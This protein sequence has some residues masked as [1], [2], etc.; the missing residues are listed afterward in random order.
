MRRAPS[1]VLVLYAFGITLGAL[2]VVNFVAAEALGVERAEFLRLGVEANLPSWFSTAQLLVVA[3]AFG[4]IAWRDVEVRRPGTWAAALPGLFFLLLS[5]DEGAQV[6]ERLGRVLEAQT[7]V[8]SGLMTGGWMFVAV[9]LY[10]A[11]ALYAARALA[12]Y[13]RGRPLVVRL[14]VAGCVLFVL[15]AAGLESLGNLTAAEDAFS[16]S[17]LGVFEE[18]GEML[19]ATT[20]LWAGVELA[21]AEGFR[22][23]APAARRRPARRT[24]AER[25][26][27][28]R[29]EP[30]APPP[31]F[32][33]VSP[34]PRPA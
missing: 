5:A 23:V 18:V 22:I 8:G 7:G 13:F 2:A 4:L 6:H 34:S 33:A 20:L 11:F 1:A 15:S 12:P 24:R 31:S 29:W 21:R 17:V 19:A 27:L 26:P 9:P 3:L 14:G 28:P 30:L 16:R 32:G 10:A 25:A